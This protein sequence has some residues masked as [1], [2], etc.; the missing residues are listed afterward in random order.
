[1]AVAPRAP[2]PVLPTAARA[3]DQAPAAVQEVAPEADHVKV[4]EPPAVTAVGVTDRAT[5]GAGTVR[6][7]AAAVLMASRVF[8]EAPATWTIALANAVSTPA[9]R[10]AAT[11]W[12][13]A[14][15]GRP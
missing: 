4:A 2:V 13:V 3:P 9:G 7:A 11:C 1:M 15:A 10:A 8:W 12:G 5:W 6:G 14:P